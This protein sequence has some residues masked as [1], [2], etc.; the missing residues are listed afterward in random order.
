M[1]GQ[2][3]S[4]LR[5][6]LDFLVDADVD[7]RE[8]ALIEVRL[9]NAV[10][11]D[12]VLLLEFLLRAE[13]KPSGVELLVL[14]ADGL[15]LLLALGLQILNMRVQV[16]DLL[17]EL[18]DVDVLRVE[19]CTELLQLLVFLLELLHHALDGGLQLVTLHRTLAHLLL[20]LVD[21]LAVALHSV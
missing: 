12:D 1:H 10:T 14:V 17:V 9:Q 20:Q 6:E 18:R 13:D 15:T 16:R 19:F 8:V 21:K 2:Q 5:I 3:L 4:R 7:L 11:L